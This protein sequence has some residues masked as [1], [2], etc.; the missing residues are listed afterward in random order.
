MTLVNYT[1]QKC[2]TQK[3][4]LVFLVALGAAAFPGFTEET[5]QGS[6]SALNP[7]IMGQFHPLFEAITAELCANK[8]G[9][10]TDP[11][12]YYALVDRYLRPRW[13]TASTASALVGRNYFESLST[14]EQSALTAA[15]DSTLVRYAF[16]GL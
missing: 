11:A 12:A 1:K 15:V 7:V 5:E 6:A 16:E 3:V 4:V 13:D 8:T 2:G 10:L 14:A 9:Y